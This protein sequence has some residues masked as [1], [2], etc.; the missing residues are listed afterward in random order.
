MIVN[1]LNLSAP[2]KLAKVMTTLQEKH[3][4]QL[5]F[6]RADFNSLMG[7]YEE[8]EAVR[9]RIVEST[10]HNTY[11]DNPKYVEACLIKEAI[12][13]FLSEVAPKRLNRRLNNNPAGGANDE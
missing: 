6:T 11:N 5:D 3:G 2:Y 13:I 1:D 8:C 7:I 12:H 10:S 9:S 4:I